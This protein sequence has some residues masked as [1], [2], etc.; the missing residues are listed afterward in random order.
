MK[1]VIMIVVLVVFSLSSAYALTGQQRASLVN[2]IKVAQQA[3]VITPF[4]GGSLRGIINSGYAYPEL[5]QDFV[6]YK[7]A[8]KS[9]DKFMADVYDG[10]LPQK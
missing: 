9:M 6:G 1:K 5:C 3:K 2:A 7:K 4:E 8:G 10:K